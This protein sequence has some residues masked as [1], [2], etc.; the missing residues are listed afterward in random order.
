M[1]SLEVKF[2]KLDELHT[3]EQLYSEFLLEDLGD[4]I[5]LNGLESQVQLDVSNGKKAGRGQERKATNQ[6]N[7][8]SL[9]TN[10]SAIFHT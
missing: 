10:I 5:F 7:I 1:Q 6:Y 4:I 8:V 3:Q 2:N 9:I